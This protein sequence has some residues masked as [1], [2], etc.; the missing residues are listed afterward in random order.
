MLYQFFAGVPESKRQ[1]LFKILAG[2]PKESTPPSFVPADAVKFQRWRI[3]GQKAW[4]SLERMLND[5][6]PQMGGFL[7]YFFETAG[8]KA[9]EK[10]PDFDL[11]KNLIGNLGDDLIFY[12]KPARGSS[13][14][15]LKS[16]P[17]L[18]LIGS[19]NPTQLASA[20]KS[21]LTI[22]PGSDTPTEREFLGRKIFTMPAVSLPLPMADTSKGPSGRS[23]NYAASSSYVALSAD[24][25]MLE[26][27][28][29]SGESQAKT[30]RATPGL[31]EAAQKVSGS[32]TMLFGYENE[33]ETMRA[34]FELLKQSLA[35]STNGSSASPLTGPLAGLKEWFD[36]SLLPSFDKVA[37]YFYYAVYAG[38]A[39]VD[40][41]AFKMYLPTP[42]ALKS[43][44]AK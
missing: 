25:S 31:T 26:E 23:L 5:I 40:G 27:Y 6:S 10:D 7:D 15:A 2:E 42:P 39:N 1:G 29:R 11:K 32:S 37:K 41:L 8:A 44:G 34:G 21:V 36:F 19:P 35:S 4:A 33:A 16:P 9:K 18:F 20:L 14:V 3:D 30:L 22:L 13:L 38:T 17:S 12:E 28:L 24:V 43:A